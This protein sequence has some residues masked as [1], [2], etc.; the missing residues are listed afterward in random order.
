MK[1]TIKTSKVETKNENNSKV[2]KKSVKSAAKPTGKKKETAKKPVA[3]KK[4][5]KKTVKATGKVPAKKIPVQAAPIIPESVPVKVT[6]A[7]PIAKV[8]R[9]IT[10]STGN[11]YLSHTGAKQFRAMMISRASFPLNNLGV[12]RAKITDALSVMG[13]TKERVKTLRE[14]L[15]EVD[16]EIMMAEARATSLRGLGIFDCYDHEN[17]KIP[18]HVRANGQETDDLAMRAAVALGFKPSKTHLI[19]GVK[20]ANKNTYALV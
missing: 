14:Q 12:A 3:K 1:K 2:S 20:T 18:S 6:D 9:E 11:I 15:G 5:E 19:A 10:Y 17:V 4:T 7:V 8:E 16:R 13:Q